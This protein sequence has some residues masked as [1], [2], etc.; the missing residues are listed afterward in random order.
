MLGV[1]VSFARFRALT[2]HDQESPRYKWVA[3]S[4]TTLGVLMATINSSI[5]LISLPAIFR[6]IH[7][8]PLLPSNASYLLWML[9]GF[10]LVSAVLVVTLGRLGD[11]FG[12]VRTYNAGFAV[13]T[14]ASILLAV[15]PLTGSDGALWLIVFRVVQGVGGAMLMASSAAI[16]TDAFPASQRGFA[17]GVSMVA[18]IAGSFIGLVVGGVLSEI[19][20]RLVFWFSVPIGAIATVWAYRSL[21]DTT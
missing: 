4:N 9:M 2:G 18:G 15:D 6:A 17:L 7:L 13:F 10:L 19:D 11:M 16:L 20:W 12:R 5:V 8:D 14:V 21:H 3:L 1:T